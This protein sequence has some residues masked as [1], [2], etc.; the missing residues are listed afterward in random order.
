MN[1]QI[2]R[3]MYFVIL[4]QGL[5][6]KRFFWWIVMVS[7][8]RIWERKLK[9]QESS[10][11]AEVMSIDISPWSEMEE[12][13]ALNLQNSCER[14]VMNYIYRNIKGRKSCGRE[15]LTMWC[16]EL[17]GSLSLNWTMLI[18]DDSCIVSQLQYFI[19]LKRNIYNQIIKILQF[20]V[21]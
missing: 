15:D 14:I 5:K 6:K 17:N 1:S 18:L 16:I 19:S 8:D 3:V 21:I 13:Q 2:Q 7:S 9:V 11:I 4:F 12:M 10:G 20:N